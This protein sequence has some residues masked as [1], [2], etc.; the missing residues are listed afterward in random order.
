[1][2]AFMLKAEPREPG[3]PRATRREGFVPAILYGGNGGN[4]ALRVRRSDVIRLLGQHGGRGLLQLD[5]DGKP[6]TVVIKEIQRD[7]VKGDVLHIDFYRVSM[8]EKVETTVPLRFEGEE[9]VAAR[10]AVLQAQL[11]EV[12]IACLPADLP[13][14]IV[15]DV[16]T[17]EPGH[18]L[19]VGQLQPPPGVEIRSDP[20]QVVATVV[21]PRAA[22][23]A[24]EQE[25]AGAGEGEAAAAG[26]QGAPADEDQGG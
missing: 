6:Q 4:V 25:A 21:M 20:E 15:V 8:T 26:G 2:S 22:E 9:A 16:S 19:T 13:E 10:G 5:V 12:E 24:G 7:P 23:E 11:R 1:M 14:E 18:A 3:R 17:L